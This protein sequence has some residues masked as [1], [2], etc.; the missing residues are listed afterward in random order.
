MKNVKI[1]IYGLRGAQSALRREGSSVK[2]WDVWG[3]NAKGAL[4]PDIRQIGTNTRDIPSC[5]KE[6]YD[7]SSKAP[8]PPKRKGAGLHDASVKKGR[9]KG[10]QEQ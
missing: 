5:K 1:C 2:D 7:A 10:A 3:N 6:T 9:R 4:N 8:P